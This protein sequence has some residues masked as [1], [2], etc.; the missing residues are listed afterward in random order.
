MKPES[1]MG[2]RPRRGHDERTHTELRSKLGDVRVPTLGT[3]TREIRYQAVF[4]AFRNWM[5]QT[6]WTAT[7]WTAVVAGFWSTVW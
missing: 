7:P 2:H 5:M 4:D 3:R 1:P 6:G